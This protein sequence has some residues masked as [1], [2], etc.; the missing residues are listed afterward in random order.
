MEDLVDHVAAA[1]ERVHR[2]EVLELAVRPPDAVGPSIL[3]PL[4]V[5][6]SQSSSSH[7]DRDVRARAAR[8]PRARARRPRARRRRAPSPAAACRAS[9]TSP[10]TAKQLRPLGEQRAEVREV[11]QAVV[12]DAGCTGA[13]RPCPFAASCQGTMFEWCSMSVRRISSPSFR[14]WRAHACAT[15]FDRLR[16]PAGEDDVSRLRRA[17]E[18]GELRASALVELGGLLGEQVDASVGVRVVPFVELALG[19]DDLARLLRRRGRVQVDERPVADRP[20]QDREVRAD[21]F[22]VESRRSP[23]RHRHGVSPPSPVSPSRP[24]QPRAR[25][26]CG[27][28]RSPSPRARGRVP[29]R[30]TSRYARRS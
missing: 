19:I 11:E 8:R 6:K 2:L 27:C 25:A 17:D 22:D 30:R 14:N 20:R 9:S 7:V 3:C 13:S 18:T 1:E 4:I 24:G 12:G 26:P 5:R 29:C 21:A 23:L 10:V 16:R 28:P 15:R